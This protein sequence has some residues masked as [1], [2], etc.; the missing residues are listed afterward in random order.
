MA[1][2]LI[3]TFLMLFVV[4]FA[5][6]AWKRT[7]RDIVRD[8]LFDLR[9]EWRSFFVDN[10]LSMELPEYA[11]VRDFINHYLRYSCRLRL[12]GLLYLASHV[13]D[14]MLENSSARIDADLA[15]AN[16]LVSKEIGRIRREAVRAV[17]EYM[18]LTSLLFVPLSALAAIDVAAH[19]FREPLRRAR[20]AAKK[21]VDGF[22]PLSGKSIELAAIA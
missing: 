12:V 3:I 19:R 5:W 4:R 7:Q 20:T 21:W 6:T 17:Q 2:A 14:D 10:G 11:K 15:S 9:D 22:D 16:P 1:N 13:A 18:I 8:R